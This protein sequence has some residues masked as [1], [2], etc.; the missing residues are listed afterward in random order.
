MISYSSYEIKFCLTVVTQFVE[1]NTEYI[2]SLTVL[3]RKK[4]NEIA[5]RS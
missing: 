1:N 4:P 5:L 2:P 3:K